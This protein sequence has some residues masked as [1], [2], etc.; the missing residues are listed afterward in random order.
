MDPQLG[1]RFTS[2]AEHL[3]SPRICAEFCAELSA[4]EAEWSLNL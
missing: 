3:C 1:F 2:L 4:E